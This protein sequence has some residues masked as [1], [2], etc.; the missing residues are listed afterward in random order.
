VTTLRARVLTSDGPDRVRWLEDA[1]VRIEDGRIAAISPGG[2]ADEDLRPGVLVPGFVD[3][4]TR[5]GQCTE[6]KTHG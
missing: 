5:Q 3:L 2:P 6:Q 1:V 4:R